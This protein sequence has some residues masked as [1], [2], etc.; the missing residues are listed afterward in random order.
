MCDALQ[1]RDLLRRAG[2]HDLAAGV[3]AFRTEIDDVVGGLDH[4]QV[5]LDQQH[6]V[7]GVD[8]PVERLQQALDVGQVQAG[9]RLVEDVDACAWT[10]AA[11]SARWRS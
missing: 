5:V 10:A 2:H 1:A 3:A 8:E 7:A 11:C 6:R 9:G 4:V